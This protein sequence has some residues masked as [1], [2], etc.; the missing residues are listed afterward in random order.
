[1]GFVGSVLRV[2]FALS[3]SVTMI[4]AAA[5]CKVLL[6]LPVPEN[7]RCGMALVVSQAAFGLALLLSPWAWIT[8]EDNL[9]QMFAAIQTQLDNDDVRPVFVLGNHTSFLDTVLA[10]AKMPMRCIYRSRTYMASYLLD[11]PLLGTVIRAM[12]HFEVTFKGTKDGDF[13]V[14]RE[15]MAQTQVR[16]DAFIAS[17]GMLCFFPE[18]QLN[19]KPEEVM[20]FRYGGIKV[21]L[22]ND[23]ILYQFVTTGCSVVWPR[24]AQV[25]GFPGS[26]RYGMRAIAPKGTKALLAELREKGADAEKADVAVLCEY[27]QGEMQSH[28]DELMEANGTL[29]DKGA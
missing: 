4:V 24:K 3:L 7:R 20:P 16:V 6:M 22:Q 2:C 21:A 29:K 17:G 27:L 12:G 9:G 23:A 14:D 26:I 13:S 8:G 15:K 19:P 18:G 10:V 5:I 28:V 25:G 1:M 11:L